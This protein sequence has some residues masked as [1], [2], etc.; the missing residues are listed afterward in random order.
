MRTILFVCT[1]L[2][3]EST[4]AQSLMFMYG[5]I[6][7]REVHVIV[8]SDSLGQDDWPD[9]FVA[10]SEGDSVFLS[11]DRSFENGPYIYRGYGLTPGNHY[12]VYGW[13]HY[14]YPEFEFTDSLSSF[15]TP[16]DWQ[17]R[18]PA[19]DFAFVAGSCSYVNDE[20]A[21]RPETPYGGGYDIYERMRAENADFNFWLGDNVYTRPSDYSSAFGIY[22]RYNQSRLNTELSSLLQTRPNL[23][24]WDDHDAGPN[25]CLGSYEHI[26]TTREAFMNHWPRG[27]Y[28]E[29]TTNDLRWIHTYSDVVIIGLD[30]RSHRTSEHSDHPQ[31]LG[32]EQIDWLVSQV[33]FHRRASFIFIAIGGQVLHSEALFENYAQYPEERSYLLDQLSKVGSNNILFLTGDRHHS[34]V[35][36]LEHNG[37]R[38]TDFT[39][40][41]LT[42]GPSTVVQDELNANRVGTYI[43]ERNYAL[44]SVTGS[45][46]ERMVHI[47]FKNTNGEEIFSFELK[48]M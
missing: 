12:T 31:I 34:E 7:H 42:S 5:E 19:P 39:I 46:D 43:D 40:S 1:M 38:I 36:Q 10:V 11:Y 18:R 21:D 32:K 26:S 6:N 3:F 28:H 14:Q 25:N 27:D 33:R 47:Q 41:P 8:E 9:G 44:I 30:N 4:Q 37:V 15:S 23:A 16:E 45:R 35:S 48:R 20:I 2:L 17:Y 24:I 13:I 22:H 29:E